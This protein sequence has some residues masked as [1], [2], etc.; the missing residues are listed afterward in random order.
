MDKYICTIINGLYKKTI[1]VLKGKTIFEVLISNSIFLDA[2]CGGRGECGKCKVKVKGKLSLITDGE[3]EFLSDEEINKG[4]RLACYAKIE[5]DLTVYIDDNEFEVETN[6]KGLKIEI[7]PSIDIKKY[8]N[9]VSLIVGM[10]VD[11]GTTTVAAFFYNLETG[12]HLYTASRINMQKAY[13]ADVM[14]RINYCTN[15]EDGNEILHKVIIEQLNEMI[16][17]FCRESGCNSSTIC[18]CVLTGNTTM[19]LLAANISVVSLGHLPFEPQSYFG[20][21]ISNEK[22]GFNINK[23]ANIYFMPIISGFLGGDAVSVMLACDYDKQEDN[24]YMVDIG[25]NGEMAIKHNGS[26]YACSTAAGPAFEGAQIKFGTGSIDGAIKKVSQENGKIKLSIIGKGNPIG[27]CGSGLLDAVSI[28]KINNIID[29]TG[30]IEQDYKGIY[31][32]YVFECDGEISFSLNDKKSI[33]I[34]QKDIREVQLA[35]AAISAGTTML[36]KSAQIEDFDVKNIYVAGG[37]GSAINMDSAGEIGLLPKH[38]TINA[39]SI[40]NAAGTGAIMALLSSNDRERANKI[41]KQVK[42]VELSGNPIFENEFI[43]RILF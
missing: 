41:S 27:I 42:I 34:T 9:Q 33:Y 26:I 18:D 3:K 23:S 12:M 8:K 21:Y 24:S 30:R 40:G 4:F 7:N 17:E 39:K 2:P 31:K 16:D 14:S 32:E 36:L 10:A 35:K 15:N 19:L 25:T 28:M 6:T 5:G 11:I 13:G 20:E 38:F 22:I 1:N 43:E 29:E 37:F